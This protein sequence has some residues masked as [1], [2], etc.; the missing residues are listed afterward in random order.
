MY[1]CENNRS[2]QVLTMKYQFYLM[3]QTEHYS[4][5]TRSVIRVNEI[6]YQFAEVQEIIYILCRRLEG[7]KRRPVL[8]DMLAG[9]LARCRLFKR[10]LAG[11]SG[12]SSMSIMFNLCRVMY[13]SFVSS[14]LK[15]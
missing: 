12:G 11:E 5:G 2:Q 14:T 7:V 13:K 8:E 1:D 9:S 3:Q 6:D 4:M 15:T 10:N